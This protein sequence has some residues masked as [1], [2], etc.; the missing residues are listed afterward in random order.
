MKK[1][2]LIIALMLLFCMSLFFVDDAVN[3]I[4]D[5]YEE[6]I[7][8]LETKQKNIVNSLIGQGGI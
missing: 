1:F 6:I 8:D 2:N 5:T 7:N 3:Y 4:S